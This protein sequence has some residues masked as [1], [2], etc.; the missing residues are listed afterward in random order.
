MINEDN[1]W[2]LSDT[3]YLK[4]EIVIIVL[5]NDLKNLK[6]DRYI[7]GHFL[8]IFLK[9]TRIYRDIMNE[10]IDITGKLPTRILKQFLT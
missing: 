1:E 10:K 8:K 5:I 3:I 2:E 6:S 7:I 4:N 9:K